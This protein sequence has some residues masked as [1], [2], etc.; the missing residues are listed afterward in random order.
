[1]SD[2]STLVKCCSIG[3]AV[4]GDPS[5]F[6]I[7]RVFDELRLDWRFLTFQVAPERLAD[8]LRGVDAL[9]FRGVRLLG[10]LRGLHGLPDE[11]L[12][13]R[14]RRTGRVSHLVGRGPL[15]GDDFTGVA[16][17]EAVGDP[18]GKRVLVLG[19]GGA[20]PSVVDA[21]VE[22]R[23]GLVCVA[24][25]DP[26][27]AESLAAAGRARA[28]A[29]GGEAPTEVATA[30]WEATWIEL[31]EHPEWIVST[32]CWP[33]RDN[34]R[35]AESIAP[36]IQPSMTLIDLGVGS[37]RAPL[38]RAADRRG[39][40]GLSGLSVLVSETALVLEAWTGLRIDRGPL[41][42]AGEEFLGV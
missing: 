33:K 7:E 8:A 5:H 12:S 6:M 23:A 36:E 1:M 16:L 13:E 42:D 2:S 39:A 9:G 22:R 27:L 40:R 26:A 32:A 35:V 30:T 41:R 29:I 21:L 18:A 14:S 37:T 20:G 11:R 28:A 10:E 24:D 17:C 3:E 4:S 34:Q 31:A 38:L 19:A 15:E 25:R